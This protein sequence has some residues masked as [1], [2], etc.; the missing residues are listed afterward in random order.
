MS[1]QHKNSK[2]N[3]EFDEH[4]SYKTDKTKE[5]IFFNNLFENFPLCPKEN[6]T[7]SIQVTDICKD[8][9]KE[10]E[11]PCLKIISDDLFLNAGDS[12]DDELYFSF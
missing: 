3:I 6:L 11:N 4:K 10:K 1:E 8:L 5:N 12:S 7:T 2:D 9:D